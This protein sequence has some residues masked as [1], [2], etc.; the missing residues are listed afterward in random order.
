MLIILF[1]KCFG[2]NAIRESSKT[3]LTKSVE[4]LHLKQMYKLSRIEE[5]IDLRAEVNNS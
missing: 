3:Q 4:E 2:F 5:L 1:V